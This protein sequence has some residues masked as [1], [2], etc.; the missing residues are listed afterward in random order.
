MGR[1]ESGKLMI[2]SGQKRNQCK[3]W[4]SRAVVRQLR[5]ILSIYLSNSNQT[6]IEKQAHDIEKE[7]LEKIY[8]TGGYKFSFRRNQSR[9][10][11]CAAVEKKI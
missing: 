1:R 6:F 10:D 11:I 9:Y 7:E 4:I 8:L 2:Q 3:I 5:G